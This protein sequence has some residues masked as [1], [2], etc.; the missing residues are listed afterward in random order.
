MLRGDKGG[1]IRVVGV[2]FKLSA[3][4]YFVSVF[5]FRAKTGALLC[6]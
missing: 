5:V 1:G 3:I 6:T 4:V 2:L